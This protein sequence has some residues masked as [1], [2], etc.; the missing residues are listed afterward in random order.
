[1]AK[2]RQQ[3]HFKLIIELDGEIPSIAGFR[4]VAEWYWI[5]ECSNDR[6]VFVSNEYR[7]VLRTAEILLRE[8][9]P[10]PKSAEIQYLGPFA[11][12]YQE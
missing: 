1:M 11:K 4:P 10:K 2:K 3:K 8:G 7:N 9:V 6:L 12:A 5:V